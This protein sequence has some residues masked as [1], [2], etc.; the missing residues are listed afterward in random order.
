[1][2]AVVLVLVLQ[3]V[4][5]TLQGSSVEMESQESVLPERIVNEKDGA[6]MVLIPAGAFEMGS[7]KDDDK[8]WE[9]PIHSVYLDAFYMDVHPVTNAQY[10]KFV[11]ETGYPAPKKNAGVQPSEATRC[12]GDM[13]GCHGVRAMGRQDTSNGG[14]V[15]KGGT[16]R[17][18][19]QGIPVGRRGAEPITGELRLDLP[20]HAAGAW[21]SAERLWVVRHGGN[22]V[23][24]VHG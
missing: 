23:G 21:F 2:R 9:R 7:P 14:A 20:H 17:I 5:A 18:Q 19:R 6:E 12:L 15:G 10:Q 1:M 22:G 13:V 8:H 16:R 24:A 3:V 11:Q 4:T